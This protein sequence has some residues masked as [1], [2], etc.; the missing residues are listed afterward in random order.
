MSFWWHEFVI[1]TQSSTH[2]QRSTRSAEGISWLD[3]EDSGWVAIAD[4]DGSE[5]A[6]SAGPEGGS[7]LVITSAVLARPTVEGS[8]RKRSVVCDTVERE[9]EKI[10]GAETDV[11]AAAVSPTPEVA[12]SE[13]RSSGGAMRRLLNREDVTG[14]SR[15]LC[16]GVVSGCGQSAS[17]VSAAP[18]VVE[19]VGTDLERECASAALTRATTESEDAVSLILFPFSLLW[20]SLL[21]A[22]CRLELAFV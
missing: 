15:G 4:S 20:Q 8:D 21:A 9:S 22:E 14:S 2:S 3:A 5:A 17:A 13:E 12:A 6:S 1:I 7:A 10:C 16:S 18:A 11:E 19:D